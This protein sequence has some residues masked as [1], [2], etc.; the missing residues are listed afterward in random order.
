LV[1][2]HLCIELLKGMYRLGLLDV[3]RIDLIV[4]EKV[5]FL[6]GVS[7]VNGVH[8]SSPHILP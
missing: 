5:F 4:S 8:R 6:C 1:C 7:S 3:Y 2:S